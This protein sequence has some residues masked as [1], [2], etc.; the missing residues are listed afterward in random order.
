MCIPF[1]E[2]DKN[3]Q[4]IEFIFKLIWV[5]WSKIISLIFIPLS[6]A[7]INGTSTNHGTMYECSIADE[8]VSL[9]PPEFSA[10]QKQLV[11]ESW[12]YVENHVTEVRLTYDFKSYLN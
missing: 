8:N 9:P 4:K 11:V 5:S 2:Y 10:E 7:K 3:L 6:T 12:H 1:K